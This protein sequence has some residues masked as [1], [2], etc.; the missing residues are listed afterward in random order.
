M[1]Y[2]NKGERNKYNHAFFKIDRKRLRSSVL[3]LDILFLETFTSISWA[4]K[5][6]KIFVL[7]HEWFCKLLMSMF[8]FTI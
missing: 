8:F 4:K 5:T 7:I 6:L 2:Y 1:L 3:C